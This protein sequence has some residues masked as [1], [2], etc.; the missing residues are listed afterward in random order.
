[1]NKLAPR[2]SRAQAMVEFALVIPIFLLV[3]IAIIDVGRGVFA[4][5]SITNGAREG[6]RLAIVNQTQASI[7]ARAVS[8]TAVAETDV[9][10]VTVTFK[11]TDPSPNY[12]TNPACSPLKIGCVAI[13]SFQTTFRPITP[14]IS[15]FL[16]SNGV[17]LTATSIEAIEFVC[18]N[19]ITAA[20][21]CPKQP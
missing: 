8:Q 18:P 15:S 1:M 16:F 5:N 13:V 21:N 4:Y 10:N 7:I 20:A 17:T 11:E 19:T 9:P 12:T 6:A 3:V 14:I 2:A